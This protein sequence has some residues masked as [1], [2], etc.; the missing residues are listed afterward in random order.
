MDANVSAFW[1]ESTHH[2]L[3][4][5]GSW[6]VSA[7]FC[8]LIFCG[9]NGETEAQEGRDSSRAHQLVG[10]RA[11]VRPGCSKYVVHVVSTSQSVS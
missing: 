11:K 5:P 6:I 1:R 4:R 7:G 9:T 2:T 3:Q 10:G 8:N